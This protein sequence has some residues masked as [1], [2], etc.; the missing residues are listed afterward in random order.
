MRYDVKDLGLAAGQA[1]IEWAE[2]PD[3]GAAQITA[4]V[5]A[6]RSRSRAAAL[7]P[8]CT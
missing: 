4:A 1:R 5:R 7:A 8:A 2:Q 3:A 6:R